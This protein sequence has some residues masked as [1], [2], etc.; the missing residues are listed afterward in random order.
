MNHSDF[1]NDRILFI[2]YANIF[3]IGYHNKLLKEKQ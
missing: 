3:I 2:D 1:D